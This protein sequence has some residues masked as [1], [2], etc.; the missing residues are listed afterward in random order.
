MLGTLGL[1]AIAIVVLSGVDTFLARTERSEN[2]AKADG[3]AAAGRA[4]IAKGQPAEAVAQFKG[5]IAIERENREY[6]LE[7]G[8]AQLAAGELTDAETT[9]T[10]LLRKD[11]TAGAANLALARVLLKQ[12]R[13]TDAVSAYHSAVYGHWDKDAEA[14]RVAVR[15]EL[16]N[17]LA[18]QGSKEELLAELLPLLDMSPN[19]LQVRKRIGRLFL[20]AGSAPRAGE[21]FRAILKEHP[22]DADA[23]EGL[24]EA[25]FARGNYQTAR[26]DFRQ[27]ANLRPDDEGIIQRLELC[28]AVLALD[29]M[30]R[31]IGGEEQH[32]RSVKMLEMVT[33][34]IGRCGGV[35]PDEAEK[36]MKARVSAAHLREAVEANLNLAEDLWKIRQKDCGQTPDDQDEPLRLVLAKIAQ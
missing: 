18:E 2:R 35:V 33:A 13:I 5:A 28:S 1:V 6:W 36:A 23:Y 7:L 22:Q 11:S 19:D 16:V 26:A 3:L 4:L 10:E 15:F 12:G 17:V 14:N 30:Q 20:V 24:G 21:I 25:E 32:A 9:L 34:A 27:A 31:G 8:Q 29:P